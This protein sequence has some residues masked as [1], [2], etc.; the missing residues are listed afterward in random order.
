MDEEINDSKEQLQNSSDCPE[1]PD[2]AHL[3]QMGLSYPDSRT[4]SCQG[5]HSSCSDICVTDN[6]PIIVENAN[7]NIE[8]TKI[9]P[10]KT[11][12]R[13]S[14]SITL[15]SVTKIDNNEFGEFD[16]TNETS[17]F[18]FLGAA[19]TTPVREATPGQIT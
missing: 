4:K 3:Y 17:N 11:R 13:N 6:Y 9:I 8:I 18:P 5:C 14:D 12:R 1:C 16:L 10:K 19:L 15:L 7:K 2:C